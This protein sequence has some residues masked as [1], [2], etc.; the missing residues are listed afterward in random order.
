M[1]FCDEKTIAIE[2]P[3]GA[4][5]TTLVPLFLLNEPW[6]AGKKILMLEP[7]R[8]AARAAAERM[9][10]LIGESVGETVGYRMRLDTRISKRT[11]I[12]VVTEGVF[13]RLIQSDPGLEDVGIVIFDEFHERSIHT[14]L[15]LAL[16]RD[17]QG[18]LNENLRICIMSATLDGKYVSEKLGDCPVLSCSGKCYPVGIEYVNRL[19]NEYIGDMVSRVV[20]TAVRENDGDILVFLPG[21]SEILKVQKQLDSLLNPGEIK[22]L[23]LYGMQTFKEQREAI[24]PTSCRR[25]KIVLAT[26][27]AETSLTIEGVTVVVDSGLRRTPKYN[28]GKGITS[29]ETEAISKA[30]SEQRRGRAG[31][32]APGRC[33]R[34]WS[35]NEQRTKTAFDKPEVMRVGLDSLLLETSQW[36][37]NDIEELDW[38]DVPPKPAVAESRSLLCDLGA[39]TVT[40]AITRTGREMLE[41]GISPRL[42]RII[43]KGREMGQGYLA[44]RI[45]ALLS[46]RDI[47]IPD[48]PMVT[49]CKLEDRLE[50]LEGLQRGV[51]GYKLRK[52]AIDNVNK[53][54]DRW[55]KA[56]GY[57]KRDADISKLGLLVALG[58]VDRIGQRR[59]G[60]HLNYLLSNGKGVS[61]NDPQY[62]DADYIV[63]PH[64]HGNDKNSTVFLA[65]A[66][67]G[68]DLHKHFSEQ[69]IKDEMVVWDFEKERVVTVLATK[70]GA[71][72]LSESPLR[73]TPS[74]R[75][76]GVVVKAIQKYGLCQLP[77]DR[78]T[79]NW[80]ARVLL[81][82]RLDSDRWPDVSDEGL[83][84]NIST[85]LAP[86]LVGVRQKKQF[87]TIDLKN[88]LRAILEPL[89]QQAL[90]QMAPSKIRVASGSELYIDYTS[91][92]LPVLPVRIQQMFGCKKGPVIA[93][94]KVKLLFHLLTPARRV[95]QITNDLERFWQESYPLV[96]KELRGRYPKHHWPEN[97]HDAIPT[98]RCKKRKR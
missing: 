5:K 83:S 13:T 74:N 2:A 8:L 56:G 36:G 92:D 3:P 42:A 44:C 88:A 87:D 76:V 7:R 37:V 46:E 77:W 71:I 97:P 26:P 59:G 73:E 1:L 15:G 16:A 41:F 82:R 40:G 33:Y 64:L 32:T 17:S 52:S 43:I 69:I 95:A 91:G 63:V 68:E 84:E 18:V 10:E 58:Y 96:R 86:F 30:S 90:N 89:E 54:S 4:G 6:L 9:A 25:R 65:A 51:D 78:E 70:L 93:N 11:R 49:N 22:I 62:S 75:V 47:L 45:A 35:C 38:V 60:S 67:S 23:T 24:V 21:V 66:M 14:D 80:Q 20:R 98:D 81:L 29:L 85:W 94:G 48:R 57:K 53:I 34:L 50:V 55:I 72:I 61:F 12:E 28:L 27:I 31:R 39:M 79:R 19:R